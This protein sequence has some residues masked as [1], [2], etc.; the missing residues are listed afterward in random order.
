[1]TLLLSEYSF[2]GAGDYTLRDIKAG[3]E[4]LTNYVSFV[5]PSEWKQEILILRSQCAG[6]EVGEITDYESG[7]KNYF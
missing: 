4:I 1:M 2:S 6:E 3:E 7:E 5:D